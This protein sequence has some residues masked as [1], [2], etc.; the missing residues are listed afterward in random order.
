[1]SVN[2]KQTAVSAVLLFSFL[3]T[4][5]SEKKV[6]RV[7]TPLADFISPMDVKLG[8]QLHYNNLSV[9][10]SEGLFLAK[11]DQFLYG[12]F[13]DGR[14]AKI[15]EQANGAWSEQ[16]VWQRLFDESF[17]S[18]VQ[19]NNSNLVVGSS[20][21][22]VYKLNPNNGEII[23][24]EVL[25]SEALSQPVVHGDLIFVRSTDGKLH[26]LSAKTGKS[27]WVVEQTLPNLSMR[28]IPEVTVMQ[29]K[30]FVGWENGK[31]A[32][33]QLQD[34]QTLWQTQVVVPK[35]RTDLE[36][37]VEIQS[38]VLSHNGVVYVLA[39]PGSLV[40]IN[41]DNGNLYWSKEVSGFKDMSVV[42]NHL[43]LVN[44]DSVLQAYDLS[45]GTKI[46]ENKQFKYRKLSD[47]VKLPNNQLL[48]GDGLGYLHWLD[49][50]NGS[51]VGRALHS[52]YETNGN[53]I[54]RVQ[55]LG[56]Y[57]YVFDADGYLTQYS[58]VDSDM[59]QYYQSLGLSL[60]KEAQND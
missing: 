59:K 55:V 17:L 18:G 57:I 5:C 19:F 9:S 39:Y 38:K 15:S 49:G 22:N 47:M 36:R 53:E 2:F 45:N 25:S 1:M 23:W 29:D 46:W 48:L 58:Q 24:H 37:L 8:W 27:K 21:A 28:G 40:A 44:E 43:V 26:A 52:P 41:P 4:S 42:D 54:V 13:P 3:L 11:Q 34:G 12:A 16:V 56:D 14:V 31:L 33:Y 35:G 10:D 50:V 7:P 20:K 60:N 6:V 32:A 30:V 51:L